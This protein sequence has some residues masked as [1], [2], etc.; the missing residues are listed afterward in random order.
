[1]KFFPT[2]LLIRRD[3]DLSTPH[4][5]HILQIRP[6]VTGKTPHLLQNK[7]LHRFTDDLVMAEILNSAYQFCTSSK[8]GGYLRHVFFFS[9]NVTTLLPDLGNKRQ[10]N[11]YCKNKDLCGHDCC[12]YRRSYF[13]V[14]MRLLLCTFVHL[15]F[16]LFGSQ[17]SLPSSL[18]VKWVWLWQRR[19]LQ[20]RSPVSL[21]IWKT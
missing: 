21:P 6:R 9:W 18:K 19:G 11:H 2:H 4:W 13:T 5:N 1:M 10:C 16:V 3:R 17:D 15:C 14:C 20:I 12:E 7:A 8:E